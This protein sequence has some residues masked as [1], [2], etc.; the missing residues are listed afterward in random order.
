MSGSSPESAAF[1]AQSRIGLGLAVTTL[2]A[3]IESARLYRDTAASCGWQPKPDDVLYRLGFHVAETDEQA[4]SDLEE[5]TKLPQRGSPVVANRALEAVIAETGY[6]GADVDSQR[7]RMLTRNDVD[8]RIELGQ[9]LLGSPD[10][11]LS[12]IETIH[13]RLGPG[14]L[15]LP[16]A[17]QL[18]ERTTRS[19][20][21][22]G[23]KVLPRIRSL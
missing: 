18:D 9:M 5:S 6:Y 17:F 11:V 2:P 22:M 7:A 19:I 13:R 4:R 20:E 1:A 14:I 3:A 23:E 15:D 21:L 10:T 8:K 16:P 12:Q